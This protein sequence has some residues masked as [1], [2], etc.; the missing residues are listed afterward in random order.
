M[1]DAG[2]F[3][4]LLFYLVDDDIGSEDQ[5]A[6]SIDATR[7]TPMGKVLERPTAVIYGVHDFAGCSGIVFCD[8][9]K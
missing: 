3:N 6:T 9:L 1:I 8:A 2:D 4:A 5:F 7:T